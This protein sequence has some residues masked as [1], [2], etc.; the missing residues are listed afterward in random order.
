MYAKA[1]AGM[2]LAALLASTAPAA[3]AA[4]LASLTGKAGDAAQ[5]RELVV[6]RKKG[7]CL[8]CHVMPIPE[9][10]DHGRIGPDLTEVATRLGE[11]ELRQQ[12]VD[13]KVV[14]PDSVMPSFHKTEGLHRVA[15]AMVG[16]PILTAQEIEDVVAYLLT[17]KP[18]DTTMR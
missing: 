1:L 3:Q 13:P 17:L 7:N 15:K 5:G 6:D 9:E 12:V 10:Q 2:A 14:N 4:G 11:A 18:T 16:K 8:A